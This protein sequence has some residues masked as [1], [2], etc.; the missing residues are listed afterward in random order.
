MVRIIVQVILSWVALT[1]LMPI[2]VGA[3]EKAENASGSLAL[4]E[5]TNLENCLLQAHS[6][7]P[8]LN[9]F[10]S[11]YEAARQRVPQAASLP[12]PVFQVTYFV[13]SVQTRTGPQE[14]AFLLSQ[15]IPWFGKLS[16]HKNAALAEAEA[17][18]YA[19]RNQQLMLARKVSLAF[20][21]YGYTNEAIRL[22]RENLDLLHKLEPVVEEK[23]RTGGN[24]NAL[25][26]LKV[27]VGKIND[28]L[29][30]LLQKRVVQSAQLTELLALPE[31][32]LLPWPTWE[33]P[34]RI[35]LD[36]PT[37]T[38]TIKANN[39]ELKM[40]ECMI[41][42]A[43]ARREIARL[44]GFPDITFGL[45]YIH[46]GDPAVNPNT[47]DAG[48][49]PWGFTVAMNIPIW[50]EKYDAAK[51]EA[52]ASKHSS[53]SEYSNR[54]NA[55]RAE[56]TASLATLTDANRRLELYGNEL[57]SLAKQAAENS[58]NSYEADQTGI[59]EVIDSERSLLDLQLIYWRAASDAWQQRIIIQTLADLPIQG[60]FDATQNHE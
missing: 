21:E 59:L 1:S 20:Y 51:A 5:Y 4:S 54:L 13:E 36:G 14:N 27:E 32:T 50:F 11:R 29:Q 53:E 15:R 31:S 9:V 41:S 8:Q 60:I 30:S 34:Q 55:L 22:N 38:A 47:P 58:R 19:Y 46:T 43:D 12:D 25:L 35:A 40:L 2:V 7:N 3:S 6:A 49:D 10:K 18:W 45:N 37:L 26:R 33:A 24:L 16:S 42:N 52:L 17:L 48:E 44:T 39:P 56:L 57:L 23:V 28:Q